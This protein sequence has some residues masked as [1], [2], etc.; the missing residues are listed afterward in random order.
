MEKRSEREKLLKQPSKMQDTMGVVFNI[1]RYSLHDGPGIRTVVFLKG[2]SLTC[3]WCCNPESIQMSPQITF[4][5]ERCLGCDRCIDVCPTGAKSR[6]GYRPEKCILCGRC[7]EVCPSGALELLGKRMS[8]FEVVREV[9]KDRLFY[10]TSGGGVT[11]SGGELL[12]QS[13]FSVALLEELA[14]YAIHTAIET[15]GYGPWVNLK[16]IVDTCDLVLFDL[17]HMDSE[18]HRKHTGVPNEL[19]LENALKIAERIIGTGKEMIFRVPLIGGVNTDRVNIETVA[20]FALKAGVREV[21]LLPY[22]RLGESKY[23]KLGMEFY[24]EAFHPS[25]DLIS[26]IRGILESHGLVVRTGG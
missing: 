13:T 22:H 21:H 12:V 15:S 7:V 6:D 25:D 16:Q 19:I 26:T 4:N 1:Q 17:K 3:Q 11:L 14:R 23:R 20:R 2:C 18:S 9:E 10:E 5:R 8:I 24:L